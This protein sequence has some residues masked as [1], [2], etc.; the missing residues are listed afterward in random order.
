VRRLVLALAATAV[1]AGCGSE[2]QPVELIVPAQPYTPFVQVVGATSRRAPNPSER[3]GIVAALLDHR[4]RATTACWGFE[5]RVSKVNSRWAD[6]G[7]AFRRPYGKCFLFNGTNVMRLS[8][9]RW[10]AV[11]AFSSN[12][13]CNAAPPG[14][15]VSLYGGC[16]IDVAKTELASPAEG[17][18]ITDA[19]SRAEAVRRIFRR[20]ADVHLTALFGPDRTFA[21][22]N[23]AGRYPSEKWMTVAL[24]RDSGRWK[25]TAWS[26]TTALDW[27][28]VLPP[29]VRARFSLRC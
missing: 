22:A 3:E 5:L 24:L 9:G 11:T 19:L 12:P 1:L 7:I 13:P 16:D 4:P 18:E 6:G 27:C 10:K 2:K 20:R 15:M 26:K 25:V 21:V 28:R 23:L 29:A 8:D 14:V 17:Q